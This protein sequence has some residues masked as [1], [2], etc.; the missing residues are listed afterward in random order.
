MSN[1]Y[2]DSNSCP[3]YHESYC[4]WMDS[5]IELMKIRNYKCKMKHGIVASI[6]E[7]CNDLI[8]YK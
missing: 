2:C 6:N 3:F 5:T 4:T 8:V 7:I 1:Y